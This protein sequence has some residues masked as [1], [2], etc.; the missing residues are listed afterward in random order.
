[1][2]QFDFFERLS[3]DKCNDYRP[4]YHN[5]GEKMTLKESMENEIAILTLKGDIVNEEDTAKVKEK[6]HSLVADEVKKVVIDLGGVNFIN[7]S[8]L[9]TL[10]AALTSVKNGGGDLR[11]AR[12]G[13][14][15]RN[16]FVITQL[17]KVFDTYETTER[18][19][20]SFSTKR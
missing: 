5:T 9:G 3:Y 16:L 1:M 11:L 8:G 17:V 7:S 13:D 6:I 15:V 12:V 10:I 14:K 4:P 19:M 18:A 20:A 2:I